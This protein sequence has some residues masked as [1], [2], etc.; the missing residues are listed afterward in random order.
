MELFGRL[1]YMITSVLPKFEWVTL[2]SYPSFDD[3]VLY[4]ENFYSR[5][6]IKKIIYLYPNDN[7]PNHRFSFSSKTELVKRR[8]IKGI[9]Y[10]MF[11]KYVFITHGLYF[12]RFPENQISINLWHG[13]PLKRIGVEKGKKGIFTT[14]TLSTSKF[15]DSALLQA[16]KI[17]ESTIIHCNLPRNLKLI[18]DS[19]NRILR[20]KF[21]QNDEKIIVW[22][23]T[24]RS[25]VEGDLRIDGKDYGNLVNLPGFD[26]LEFNSFL[27]EHNLI[28]Y[29]KPHPMANYGSLEAVGH[30]NII[31]DNILYEQG[32]SVYDLLSQADLLI[33]DISSV[34]V[35]YLLLNRP[36][37]F[38]FSDLKE[39]SE[40][41]GLS[42]NF[43]YDNLP[44]QFCSSIHGLM[45]GVLSSL[46]SSDY[47]N[48]KRE[49]VCDEFHET[50][51]ISVLNKFLL[52]L[53]K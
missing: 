16:F 45:D 31:N 36:I 49:L 11:S 35:D 42:S 27:A 38:C 3:N 25:S 1:I 24:Y 29:I 23:P 41:R 26:P 32:L 52:E 53:L 21:S 34:I 22:L 43:L 40:T 4:V 14:Y 17:D 15:F 30:L 2:Q 12:Y 44:G 18:E 6:S 47:F 9:I 5:T 7:P 46:K 39:Y 8:S 28:C 20:K 48:S 10:Y 13:M 33:S 37:L 51:D 19:K 50:K